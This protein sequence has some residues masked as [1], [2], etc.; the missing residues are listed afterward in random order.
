MATGVALPDG[1]TTQVVVRGLREAGEKFVDPPMIAVMDAIR[2]D[3]ALYPGG[4]TTADIEYDEK[5]GEVLRPISQDKSGMPIGFEIAAAL[6]DDLTSAFFLDKIQ[7]PTFDHEMTAYETQRRFEQ[8]IRQS[9][10]LFEPIEQEYN[11]PLCE[12]TFEELREGGAFGP[13][14]AMPEALRGQEVNFQF[15]SPVSDM[16][17]QNDAE[18]YKAIM[19][20]MVMPAVQMDPAQIQNINQTKSL[21]DAMMAA[22]WKSKWMNPEEAVQQEQERMSKEA[23]QQ[24]GMESIAGMAQT[25][26]TGG[27]ALKQFVDAEAVAGA[28]QPEQEGA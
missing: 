14:E 17:E 16:V 9:A 7:L 5:L 20:E 1:R 24:A 8:Y 4:V 27:K 13:V 3:L 22:G 11:S 21:R 10:P 19:A 2:S 23:E 28:G 25:A 18:I 12:L 6:R 15:R 26:E